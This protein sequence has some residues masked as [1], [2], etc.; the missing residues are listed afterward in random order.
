[1]HNSPDL[2]YFSLR[3]TLFLFTWHNPVLFPQ[4]ILYVLSA[5]MLMH[6]L[7]TAEATVDLEAL[8]SALLGTLARVLIPSETTVAFVRVSHRHRHRRNPTKKTRAREPSKAS[9]KFPCTAVCLHL[10]GHFWML[11]SRYL[12]IVCM[13]QA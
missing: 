12:H 10:V 1:M 8:C 11:S 5:L 9:T 7:C 3:S 2:S 13:L 4:S 6:K